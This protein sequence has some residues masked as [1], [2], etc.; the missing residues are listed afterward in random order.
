MG[1]GR[2]RVFLFA[3]LLFC[4]HKGSGGIIV[5]E[6]LDI[7]NVGK[8]VA[9]S[10]VKAWDLVDQNIEFSEVPIPILHK[11]ENKLFGKIEKI[12]SRLEEMSGRIDSIGTQ[13]MTTI[14]H[15]LP[16]R[17]RLELRLNDLL[18]YL[19]RMQTSYNRM[20]QYA[21]ERREYERLTLEN[22]AKSV[23]S[24]DTNSAINLVERIHAF[25]VPNGRGISNTGLFE[26]LAIS[27]QEVE[28]DMICSTNQSPQQVLYNLYDTIA[29]TELK[30]YTMVQ[31]SYMLLR[32]YG[33]G[34]FTK[35]S[36]HSR[37]RYQERTNNAVQSIKSAMQN[38]SRDLWK[39]DPKKHVKGDTYVEITNLLQGYVQNEVDLNP[40]GTCRENCAEYVYTKSHGCY[41]NQFCRQQRSCSGKIID[42]KFFDSDM[43]ICNANPLSGRRYEYIEYENG[44]ILGRKQ[45]CARGSTKVDSWWRWLFWHCS[46]CFC[47]CD[48]QGP[49]SDRYFSMRSAISDLENNK[50]VTGMR[51]VKKN[52]IIHLQIQ[53]A[54]LLPRLTINES[55]VAWKPLEEFK[56]TDKKIYNGQDYHTMSWEK[57]A[58]DLDD[59][60]ADDGYVLTGVR[61]KEIGSHL[62][63]EIYTTKFDFDSGKLKPQH[64]KWK[65]NP[66]TEASL[67]K[68]RTK[69]KLTHPD[70]PTRSTGP[71]I[72]TSHS[73][74]YIEFTH[75]DID[76]DAAQ[77]TV[78]YLDAQKVESL[79]VVPLS[80][81]GIYHKGRQFFGGFIA[82]KIITYDFS[83]FLKPVFPEEEVNY[84]SFCYK[85]TPITALVAIFL[86]VTVRSENI[87]EKHLLVD[88]LRTDFMTIE[89]QLWNFV[90][91][92]SPF[93]SETSAE[94]K[95]REKF[96]KF[97]EEI[98]QV[99]SDILRG[100]GPLKT[101]HSFLFLYSDI[102]H[103]DHIYSKFLEYLEGHKKVQGLSQTDKKSAQA[104]PIETEDMVYDI[105][106]PNTGAYDTVLKIYNLT[107]GEENMALKIID[108]L[109]K[110]PC[111]YTQSPQ[112][113]FYNLYNVIALNGLKSYALSQF[114]YMT[115][116]IRDE[117]NYTAQSNKIREEF[118]HRVNQTMSVF[119]GAMIMMP[120]DLWK[121]DA[122]HY[123]RGKT[124]DEFTRLLQGHIQNEVDMNN[125][126]TCTENC[127]RYSVSTS[128]GCYDGD[129][130]YCREMERC[131]GK[132]LNCRFVESHMEICPSK[133]PSRRYEYIK[134]ES[135]KTFG[136][137][138]Y[139]HKKPINSWY[140]WFVHCS[141]CFCLCDEESS[142]SDRFF[143]LRPVLANV[144]DNRVVTGIKFIKVN[145]VMHLQIQEGKLLPYGY[146][147]NRT[148]HWVPVDS[149]KITDPGVYNDQDFFK[150]NFNRRSLAL[151]DVQ[152]QMKDDYVVT[153]VRLVHTN[154]K[155]RLQVRYNK[156]NWTSGLLSQNDQMDVH[157]LTGGRNKIDLSASDVPIKTAK[158]SENLYFPSDQFVEFT[159]TSESADAAQTTIPFV[160]IQAVTNYPQV[161]LAGIG[162]YYKGQ[163]GY[164]GFIAPK[165]I[166]FNYNRFMTV[167]FNQWKVD[168]DFGVEVN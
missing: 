103:L 147:D 23:I 9:V 120:R 54:E 143:N 88:K 89:E 148:V 45:G 119:R 161:P 44:R 95:V 104:V 102:K 144:R 62:N 114:A 106:N 123:V 52:R 50:V 70:I 94:D 155:L 105:L 160:D 69:V 141:Y 84:Q 150:M 29:L 53:E 15:S 33:H 80:G 107:F 22:F 132:L 64:S 28:G 43:W 118:A 113:V 108:Y 133:Y 98:K 99:P 41:A 138:Q 40:E 101:V 2:G 83:K 57:R 164:G 131:G 5:S 93:M 24:H 19:T 3:A 65:D 31:F 66:N 17:V 14:L 91:N 37:E 146:I 157:L 81:A 76:R 42:C 63:F 36:Q 75:S 166:T 46:Y 111:E 73:D 25:V 162:L 38:V 49:M 137:N 100:T 134:Y 142:K 128:T 124:Y 158:P 112:Q 163:P 60:E 55:T 90:L 115:N 152:T 1:F 117:G 20:Q 10:L 30:G 48:E 96:L 18:D 135:G 125:Q 149:Y 35:E 4:C 34:N 92:Q 71:S 122:T 82:P 13:S 61:F 58:L 79:K 72:P 126:G 156:F 39:C 78:P 51:F 136:K 167:K 8:E 86:I 59:L 87:T 97:S 21:T 7:L 127:A 27:M 159:H 56:I 139:C 67:N 153:G 116:A 151:D 26:L 85:M 74:Q 154:D 130:K 110:N 77:T 121:C 68:P 109:A 129:S 47:L 6:I 12:N 32:L 16:D 168:E 145:R 11:T 140:R 165:I